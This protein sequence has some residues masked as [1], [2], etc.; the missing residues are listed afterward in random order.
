MRKIITLFYFLFLSL[1][2]FSQFDDTTHHYFRFGATGVINRT[3]DSKSSVFANKL[4]F[5]TKGKTVATNTGATWLY[6]VQDDELTNNDFSAHADIEFGK[7]VHKLY[8]WALVN[9][10]KSFSLKI[11]DRV[12][13]GAGIGYDFI[14]SPYLKIN[15]SDGILYE[16]GNIQDPVNDHIMYNTARNSFR[17]M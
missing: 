12:Q 15:V 4:G 10:D 9:Y 7:G 2:S 14:D 6:G 16:Y 5:S 11:N 13:A 1:S 8:Y 17:L 3:N